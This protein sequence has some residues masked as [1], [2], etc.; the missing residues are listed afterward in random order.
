M[1]RPRGL[2][3]LA[4]AL[5]ACVVAVGVIATVI[6]TRD[7]DASSAPTTGEWAPITVSRPNVPIIGG[8]VPVDLDPLVHRD[9]LSL[10]QAPLPGTHRYEVTISN[11]SDLGAINSFQWYPPAKVRILKLLGSSQGHCTLT[12][13]KGFGGNQFPTVVLYPNVLCDKLDLEPP[14]CTCLGDGGIMTISFVTDNEYGGGS[15]ELRMH[16]ATLVFDRIPTYIKPGST[17]GTPG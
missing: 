17:A 7:G 10:T 8:G 5:A 11:T 13:L 1:R 6:V 9:D 14:S 12:G 15:G 16:K 3:Q 2:A 4:F